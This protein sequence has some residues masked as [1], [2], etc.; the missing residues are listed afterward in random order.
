MKAK[1][2]ILC[3]M[4]AT[5]SFAGCLGDTDTVITEEG[6]PIVPG[7]LPDDWPTYYVATANDLPTCDAN[8][9]GR[10]YY[11]EADT[12]FQACMST[13]W[14]VVQ[15]GNTN[16]N[17]LINHPPRIN[18]EVTMSDDDTISE[19]GD[20]T[21]SVNVGFVWNA[22]DVDGTIAT[23]GIDYTGDFTIDYILADNPSM[24]ENIVN[25]TQSN[26]WSDLN[27]LIPIPVEAGLTVFRWA[28]SLS[29]EYAC[30]LSINREITFI[31]IDD[32]NSVS[33]KT[34]MV[35]G[36]SSSPYFHMPTFISL[37][38]NLVELEMLGLISQDD[39]DWLNGADP[40]SP[41]PAPTVEICDGI[42][43][44]LDGDVDED[45]NFYTDE[46]NCGACGAV[47]PAGTICDAGVC[48]TPNSPP[49]IIYNDI[50]P[51][52]PRVGELA[53]CSYS[54]SDADNDPDFTEIWWLLDGD[55]FGHGDFTVTIPDGTPTDALLECVIT[56]SDGVHY[57]TPWTSSVMI[58]NTEPFI[59]FLHLEMHTF[60][61]TELE[62]VCEWEISDAN[63]DSLGY[64][65]QWVV[66]G[67]TVLSEPYNDPG[68]PIHPTQNSMKNNTDLGLQSGQESDVYCAIADLDDGWASNVY[69]SSQTITTEWG[70]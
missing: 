26:G 23:L 25:P 16:P 51:Q 46:N 44:D 32:D 40:N 49:D 43:N 24:G 31:A 19:D 52:D 4:M 35:D 15:L 57:L 42:D 60:S 65:I 66:D 56:A 41:C 54:Y 38:W 13:G 30:S 64:Y 6:D 5:V 67:Q 21:Y 3:L 63:Y 58:A 28:D 11:V 20:G 14:Q 10:L 8:T 55:Q 33:T 48:L 17:V 22:T 53:T 18:V 36:L 68:M 1:S 59:H 29:T 69:D 2:I 7:E 70:P 50:T 12:N 37:D 45:W 9:L 47:C 61:S 39:I 62:F 34:L 27:G